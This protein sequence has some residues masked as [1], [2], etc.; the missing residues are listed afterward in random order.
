MLTL[1]M[2]LKNLVA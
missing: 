1:R 2:K